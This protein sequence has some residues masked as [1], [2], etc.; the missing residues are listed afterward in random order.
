MTVLPCFG[1]SEDSS[2]TAKDMWD[3]MEKVIYF[4]SSFSYYVHVD[5]ILCQKMLLTLSLIFAL[6][7]QSYK[8]F[9]LIYMVFLL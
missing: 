8:T 5:F 4:V 1:L 6:K 2:F 9:G 3:T 7:C